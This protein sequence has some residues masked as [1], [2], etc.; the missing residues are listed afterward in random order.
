MTEL[1]FIAYILAVISVIIFVLS[2]LHRFVRAQ[3]RSADAL[4]TIARKLKDEN[5]S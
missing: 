2:V 1:M 4:E 3:E 5:E